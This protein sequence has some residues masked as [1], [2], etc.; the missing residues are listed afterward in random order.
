MS[1]LP[2]AL[3]LSNLEFV[4]RE[5]REMMPSDHPDHDTIGRYFISGVGGIYWCD[6]YDPAIGFWMTPA[7]DGDTTWSD[8][9]TKRTNVS[10]R[11]IGRTFHRIYRDE[12]NDRVR[13]RTALINAS[14]KGFEFEE[15]QLVT[16]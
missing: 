1:D 7:R 12:Y 2:N 9:P 8:L 4:Q 5:Q 11:A 13:Y 10:E 14:I 16:S 3:V 6:S 15:G